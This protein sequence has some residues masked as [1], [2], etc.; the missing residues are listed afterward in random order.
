MTEE[1]DESFTQAEQF[2]A[3]VQR[4]VGYAAR[5][6]WTTRRSSGFSRRL[7]WRSKKG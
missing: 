6:A 1:L 4:L 3:A 7:S 5:R 2:D